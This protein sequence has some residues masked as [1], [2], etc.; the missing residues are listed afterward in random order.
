MTKQELLDKLAACAN[1]DYGPEA[2]HEDADE[3]LIAFIN[4]PEITEAFNN[5]EKW[6]S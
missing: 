2:G 1:H 5:L 6:Y 3:A 4:D